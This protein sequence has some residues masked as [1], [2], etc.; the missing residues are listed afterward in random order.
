[1]ITTLTSLRE[2]SWKFL[3]RKAKRFIGREALFLGVDW[4]S[5][6]IKTVALQADRHGLALH[7]FSMHSIGEK[8]VQNEHSHAEIV[9]VILKKAGSSS[10][11]GTSLSG[12]SV[13]VKT[14]ILPAMPEKDLRGHLALE[15]D[16][17][18][19][20]DAQNVFWDVY[21][22]EPFTDDRKDQQEIFLIVATKEG[23]ES[24]VEAFSHYGA[25]IRFVDVD[26]FAL[27]NLVTFNYG[28]EGAWALAHIGPTGM[29]MV[30]IVQG[31]P[32]YIRKVPYKSEWYGDLLNQVALPQAS[33][34]SKKELGTSEALLLEDFFQETEEQIRETMESF[35]DHST[36]VIDRG[37]LLSGGYSVVPEMAV[38]L[39]HSLGV[40][41][42]LMDPFE[43][44]M[45]PPAIKQDPVFQQTAPL[46]GVAVGVALRGALTH[47]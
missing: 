27:I 38:T 10:T 17:Y 19:A 15:L 33:L 25:T 2:Y 9:E 14:I 1:M 11:I 13:F 30:V 16:R 40:S 39:S 18:I 46:M 29:V 47:D 20:L 32:A 7:D 34:Q 41:V 21:P 26:V 35:A 12:P 4:G 5:R 24:Q 45:V 23:V 31:E 3:V 44:I 43:A 36:V 8:S 42:N 37:I 22:R 28:K 6:M